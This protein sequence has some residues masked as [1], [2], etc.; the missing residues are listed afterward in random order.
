MA[1]PLIDIDEC[2]RLI[3][4]AQPAGDRAGIDL[5]LPVIDKARKDA[6]PADYGPDDPAR[7]KEF[8][9]ADWAK[10]INLGT[11]ALAG[12]AT[13]PAPSGQPIPARCKHLGIAARVT[14]ALTKKHGFPGL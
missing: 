10:I 6:D 9:Q 14:E 1:E 8:V 4:D 5:I 7:P 12:T 11:A 13:V 2:L 3:S